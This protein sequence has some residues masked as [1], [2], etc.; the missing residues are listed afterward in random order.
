[1]LLIRLKRGVEN[2]VLI[3]R[4]FARTVDRLKTN[5]KQL[6]PTLCSKIGGSVNAKLILLELEEVSR[7]SLVPLH[8]CD[9][10]GMTSSKDRSVNT[11]VSG[12]FQ[13]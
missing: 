4:T 10:P 2:T 12:R 7:V 5:M 1:M 9:T 3:T 6:S 11:N 8:F 13:G